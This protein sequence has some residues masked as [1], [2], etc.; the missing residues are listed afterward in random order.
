MKRTA[1]IWLG[2]ALFGL[3][4]GAVVSVFRGHNYIGGPIVAALLG[5][6]AFRAWYMAGE[7]R[8]PQE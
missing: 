5:A 1:L 7:A 2:I 6:G 4:A 8:S 3:A